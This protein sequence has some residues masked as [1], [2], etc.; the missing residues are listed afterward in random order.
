M[1]I[2]ATPQSHQ[3]EAIQVE[4]TLPVRQRGGEG[5]NAPKDQTRRTNARPRIPRITRLMAL[6]I[7]FQDMLNRGEVRD[8]ADLARLGYV[9]RARVTQIMNLLLLAPDV[10]EQLL[11]AGCGDVTDVPAER[12]LRTVASIAD[13]KMQRCRMGEALEHARR[14]DPRI[15][16]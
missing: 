7:K 9:T 16:R 1:L 10:Q 2:A 3:D 12:H 5:G 8:Y 15:D 11:F 14:T 6:A 13:W 4:V